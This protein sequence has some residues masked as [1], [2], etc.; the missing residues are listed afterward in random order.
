MKNTK[1]IRYQGH[2]YVAAGEQ[3]IPLADETFVHFTT[4]DR[5]AQV[6]K[7]GKLL[8]DPPYDKFGTDTVNAVSLTYGE[9]VPGTQITHIQDAD[10]PLV[11]IKFRT[12]T[13]PDY[14]YVE[15]VVW[16][17]DVNLI[18]AQLVEAERAMDMLDASPMTID[19]QTR[20]TYT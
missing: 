9:F 7:D 12:D 18:D 11:A 2:L 14:G 1:Y 13:M 15:E 16:H 8:M 5:A 6:L 10:E 4:T 20:I 17:T 19:A 3:T